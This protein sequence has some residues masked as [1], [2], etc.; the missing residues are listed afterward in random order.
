MTTTIDVYTK[1]KWY[2]GTFGYAF[3][4]LSFMVECS[5]SH[6]LNCDTSCV[7]AGNCTCIPGFTGIAC[8]TNIDECL[9]A[10]CPQNSL[11]LDGIDDYTCECFQGFSG[12]NCT[13]IV[14][15]SGFTGAM[16]EVNIDNCNGVNCSESGECVD[17]I[18]GYACNCDRGFT[19]AQCETNISNC[20]GVTCSNH[21]ECI[22]GVNVY[23]CNC[24]SSF[25]GM[26]CEDVVID[27]PCVGVNCSGHGECRTENERSIN[28]VCDIGYTGRL[29]E[30]DV[31][32][33][34]L[35]N[36]SSRQQCLDGVNS[37]RC[38]CRPEYTGELCETLIACMGVNCSGNGACTM[39]SGDNIYGCDCYT[40]FTGESCDT[41]TT[42][43]SK[44]I[45]SFSTLLSSQ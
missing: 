20:L 24:Q 21:G 23:T 43:T 40:G 25:T 26:N 15:D 30:N 11:C 2:N 10:N 38:I 13:T 45:S 39:K 42:G 27:D 35:A 32:D 9:E 3:I 16:C 36:C 28:C 22:D 34:A 12:E 14:C 44:K 7:G 18:N 5:V 1:P 31:N 4:Q 29:C 33:C 19:G 41:N 8:E 17:G 6:Y 37:Y